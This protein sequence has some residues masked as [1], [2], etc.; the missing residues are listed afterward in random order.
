MMQKKSKEEILTGCLLDNHKGRISIFT[1]TALKRELIILCLI[2]NSCFRIIQ[3]YI[4]IPARL[5]IIIQIIVSAL[6]EVAM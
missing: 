3:S 2:P 6:C 5:K 1:Q 4:L